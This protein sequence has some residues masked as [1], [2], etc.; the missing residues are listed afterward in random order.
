M[1]P[2]YSLCILEVQRIDKSMRRHVHRLVI[3]MH[4]ALKYIRKVEVCI[5][6]MF[7]YI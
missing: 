2:I 7:I 6:L 5:I 3:R 1:G 4:S